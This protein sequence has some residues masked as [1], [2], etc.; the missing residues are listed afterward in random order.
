M[1]TFFG[2]VVSGDGD[3]FGGGFVSGGGAVSGGSEVLVVFFTVC[4]I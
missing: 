1:V 4:G 3:V 2:N